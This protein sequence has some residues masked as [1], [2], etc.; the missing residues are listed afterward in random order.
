MKTYN[1]VKIP[2]ELLELFKECDI[3]NECNDCSIVLEEI[4][5][6]D[7]ISNHDL[8]ETF[9]ELLFSWVKGT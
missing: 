1:I 9:Q 4:K 7:Y 8:S 5:P 2:K 3:E 6:I